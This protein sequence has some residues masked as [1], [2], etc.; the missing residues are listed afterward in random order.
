MDF[1]NIFERNIESE[2][3][4]IK[5]KNEDFDFD[6]TFFSFRIV[7]RCCYATAT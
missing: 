3:I 2:D 1:K 7:K 6:A 5:I 4:F